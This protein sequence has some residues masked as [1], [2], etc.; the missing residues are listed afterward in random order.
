[1]CSWFWSISLAPGKG[2]IQKQFYYAK[3]S[4]GCHI[5]KGWEAE[6]GKFKVGEQSGGL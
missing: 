6:V 2:G 3:L 1:M 5:L 4:Q